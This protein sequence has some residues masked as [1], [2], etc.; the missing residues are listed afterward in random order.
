MPTWQQIDVDKAFFLLR[1][2][3]AGVT[4][5][6]TYLAASEATVAI[7]RVGAGK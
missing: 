5:A 1:I 4:L 3:T 6:V 2:M 7:A